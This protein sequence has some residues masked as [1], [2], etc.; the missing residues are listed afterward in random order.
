MI[1]TNHMGNGSI[2][3]LEKM[4]INPKQPRN[5]VTKDIQKQFIELQQKQVRPSLNWIT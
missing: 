5:G 4:K 3:V 1:K 2:A